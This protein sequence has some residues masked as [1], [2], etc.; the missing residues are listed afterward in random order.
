MTKDCTKPMLDKS[1]RKWFGCSEEGHEAR[2]SPH[3][4]KKKK[5]GFRGNDRR[6][7]REVEDEMAALT[8]W[9]KEMALTGRWW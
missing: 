9:T 5:G 4:N 1:K 6:G 3:D 2:N 7:P 8:W